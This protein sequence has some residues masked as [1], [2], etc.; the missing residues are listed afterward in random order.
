MNCGEI[1]FFSSDSMPYGETYGQWTVKWW[2]W[3]LSTPKSVNPIID[4]TGEYG[5][6]NQPA[7]HVWFLAGKVPN[8]HTDL[9]SRFCRI[10]VGRSILFPVINC[11]ANELEYPE[12]KTHQDVIERVER[13]ED[14]IVKRECSVNGKRIDA[15]RVKS[16]PLIFELSINEDT[17]SNVK[18]GG[19]TSAAADGYWVFLRPPPAG[20]HIISFEGACEYG[21][22]KSGATYSLL[23]SE[24]DDELNFR[25]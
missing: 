20:E 14:S 13:D 22:L 9:P 2:Q 24:H 5:H 25:R 17:I 3:M 12:L 21:K 23:V 15:I 16:D 8:E 7:K 11:E 6:V 18:N 10:P 1:S 19:V 4:R